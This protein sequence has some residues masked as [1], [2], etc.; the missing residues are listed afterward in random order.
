MNTNLILPQCIYHHEYDSL[1]SESDTDDFFE[2]EE[3]KE[4]QK[5]D[6]DNPQK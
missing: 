2:P 1:S 4:E 3:E 5:S 6:N